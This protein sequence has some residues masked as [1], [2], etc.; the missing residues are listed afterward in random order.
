MKIPRACAYQS[1]NLTSVKYYRGQNTLS[2]DI[3]KVNSATAGTYM[4]GTNPKVIYQNG[5]SAD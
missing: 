1:Q 2:Y 3:Y 4:S 5:Q